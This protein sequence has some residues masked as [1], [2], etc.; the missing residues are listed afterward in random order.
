MGL[1]REVQVL[2]EVQV[3]QKSGQAEHEEL[4]LR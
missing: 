1:R 4:A 3:E 2:A